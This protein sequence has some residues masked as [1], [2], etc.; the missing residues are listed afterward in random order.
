MYWGRDRLEV[1]RKPR[2]L[3]NLTLESEAY[4]VKSGSFYLG[5]MKQGSVVIDSVGSGFVNTEFVEGNSAEYVSGDGG[6]P[7]MNSFFDGQQ[8]K[9]NKV[10]N[11]S[12]M[13]TGTSEE[14]RRGWPF[15]NQRTEA[16]ET[17]MEIFRTEQEVSAVLISLFFMFVSLSNVN[18]KIT[19]CSFPNILVC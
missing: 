9:N 12:V 19:G 18:M 5:Y 14:Q 6:L 4:G 17:Q 15:T 7:R 2:F 11:I 10:G 1:A 16:S 3:E 8:G 13:L